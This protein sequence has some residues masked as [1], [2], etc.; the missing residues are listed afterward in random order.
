M[1]HANYSLDCDPDW[2]TWV[3]ESNKHLSS[4]QTC[5]PTCSVLINFYGIPITCICQHPRENKAVSCHHFPGLYSRLSA[6]HQQKPVERQTLSA[7]V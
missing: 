6:G 7:Q 4:Y 1:S 3:P 2:L 5:G